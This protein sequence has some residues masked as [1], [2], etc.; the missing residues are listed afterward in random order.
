MDGNFAEI[1]NISEKNAKKNIKDEMKYENNIQ[2]IMWFS[3]SS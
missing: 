1:Y 3:F 2:M